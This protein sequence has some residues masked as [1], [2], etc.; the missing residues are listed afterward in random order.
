MIGLTYNYSTLPSIVIFE[1]KV[2]KQI[3]QKQTTNENYRMIAL[4]S[5]S[6]S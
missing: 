2:C 4:L 6:S 3:H 5:L 1:V